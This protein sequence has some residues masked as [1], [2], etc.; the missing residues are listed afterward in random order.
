VRI[1]TYNVN[2][3]R[4]RLPIVL[5][6]LEEYKP[7]VLCLQETKVENALFP[8]DAFEERGYSCCVHGQKS[9]NG[10]AILSRLKPAD[11]VFGYAPGPDP[12]DYRMLKA[13]FGAFRVINSYVPNGSS[14][15]SE[16][17]QVK[18]R[19]L[20]N[21]LSML[22]EIYEPADNI[23]WVGD[24]NI[25]PEPED[26]FDSVK[27]YGAVGHHPEEIARLQRI[28]DWGFAD[29]FRKFESGPGHYTFWEFY[30]RQALS[31]NLGWRIDHIYATQWLYEHCTKCVI[32][33][34]PRQAERP[35]DHTVVY[36]DFEI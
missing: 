20:D 10:V 16:K 2:S 27:M 33:K 31:R 8:I 26:V 13:D 14:V 18:L 23:I 9:Y 28:L 11:I 5:D 24:I 36:A 30:V 15:S 29:V 17:F 6:W 21:F 1:A 35:S 34:A 3:V 12:E 32:D 25:A 22:N 19:W 7:D 4:V